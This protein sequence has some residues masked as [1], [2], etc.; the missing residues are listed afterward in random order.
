MFDK[1]RTK[2]E[3]EKKRFAFWLALGITLLIV[4]MWFM[5]FQAREGAQAINVEENAANTE[6]PASVLMEQVKALK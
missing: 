1:V 4:I 2:T 6:G 3:A 5:S